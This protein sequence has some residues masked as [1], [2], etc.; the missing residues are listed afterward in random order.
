MNS[1]ISYWSSSLAS[2]NNLSATWVDLRSK[3]T[4]SSATETA[5]LI[6]EIAPSALRSVYLEAEGT[7]LVASETASSFYKRTYL[8]AIYGNNSPSSEKSVMSFK[9]ISVDYTNSLSRY[10]NSLINC[11]IVLLASGTA[12]PVLLQQQ[13]LV[14]GI[15]TSMPFSNHHIQLQEQ[16]FN[17]FKNNFTGFSIGFS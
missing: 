16:L 5:R 8:L 9:I 13:L 14:K 7:F 12:L 6:I 3:R 17:S 2:K 4:A 10:G 1:F 11:N 15:G